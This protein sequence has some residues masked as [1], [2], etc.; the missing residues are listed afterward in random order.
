MNQQPADNPANQ[1]DNDFVASVRGLFSPLQSEVAA[2]NQRIQE[3]DQ[4]I[5]GDLLERSLDIPIGHD[6]T[7]INWLRRTV[8]IHRAQF[9][10]KG[11]SIDSSYRA[12]DISAAGA[13]DQNAVGDPQLKQQAE[14]EKQRLM[15]ENEKRKGYAELRRQIIEAIERD[16]GGDAFWASCAENASAVGDAV[17]KAW[18]DEDEKKYILQS[19]ETIDNFYALW[20]RDDYRKH[21]AVAYVYQISKEVAVDKYGVSANVATSPLG[22][23]L[24]VLSSANMTQYVSTQPMVTIMEITGK[25]E[26]WCTDGKGNLSRCKVGK[27]T[28]LNAI[29]VGNVVYQLIDDPKMIPHYYILPNKRARR[30]PWGISDISKAAV[31]INLTY[32]ETLSDWRTVSSKVNFPKFKGFGF[33]PGIQVPKPKTRT[34]EVLPLATG[35]DIQP[36]TMGQSAGIAEGDFLHQMNE[37]ESQFVR[38]VGI[39]R[40]LFDMPDTTGNSNPALLTSMKSVSDITNVKRALWEPIIRQIF[41]DALRTMAKYDSHIAEVVNTDDDWHIKVSW[42]SAMNADDPSYH[43]MKLNQFNTGLLSIQSFLE[44]IGKDKQEID[45]IREEM[46]DPLTASIHGHTLSA[47]AQYKL[48]PFGTP[49]PP[50]VSVSLRGDM[51]PEQEGNLAVAHGFNDGPFGTTMGPQGQEG[52]TAQS[53]VDNQGLIQGGTMHGGMAVN[54]TPTGQT[55]PPNASGMTQPPTAPQQG[56]APQGGSSPELINGPSSNQPGVGIMSQP[57]SGAP[58][59]SAAGK[60]KQHAQRKGH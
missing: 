38:E 36:I 9:M 31:G 51:T 46:E 2:R 13:D 27:E 3:N 6:N 40:Q 26:G 60:L 1:T 53:N 34:V 59:T 28:E 16:N 41:E 49:Q 55:A 42:P 20:S 54:K 43:S 11:F 7:P 17:I 10:G 50:R 23:P 45:R 44:D 56:G 21:E 48:I 57:G 37:L 58:M 18:Y 4:Y 19:I 5:Y 25:I 47:M 30:R 14:A 35:Q 22:T 29:I 33:P 15:I 39:S 52:L 32:I 24:V 8:E 12:E